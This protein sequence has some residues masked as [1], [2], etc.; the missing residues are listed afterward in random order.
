MYNRIKFARIRSEK[1][2]GV[3]VS[4]KFTDKTWVQTIPTFLL[5]HTCEDEENRR[6]TV[7]FYWRSSF[8]PS[9]SF[10]LSFFSKIP[11]TPYNCISMFEGALKAF[12]VVVVF[13]LHSSPF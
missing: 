2:L 4:D 5:R 7:V 9:L 13:F 3:C 8:S 12:T 10:L 1:G 6:E 11:S